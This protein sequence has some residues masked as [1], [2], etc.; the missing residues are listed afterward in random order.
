MIVRCLAACILLV[1]HLLARFCYTVLYVCACSPW[2]SIAWGVGCQMLLVMAG[3]VAAWQVPSAAL[4]IQILINAPMALQWL[5]SL[6]VLA[7]IH[8]Q[9]RRYDGH[10]EQRA[11]N[12]GP[13]REHLIPPRRLRRVDSDTH[14][15]AE[16][17]HDDDGAI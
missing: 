2:R 10:V 6:G 12:A 13:D 9:Q 15:S 16:D 3:R 7:H 11:S 14:E 1:G 17:E 5:L 4:S 8:E